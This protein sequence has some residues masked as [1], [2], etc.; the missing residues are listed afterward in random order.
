MSTCGCRLGYLADL[1]G[2]AAAGGREERR[3]VEAFRGELAADR[4]RDVRDH[5][6]VARAF[7]LGDLVA[8]IGAAR[9]GA[10]VGVEEVGAAMLQYSPW[11][12][13]LVLLRRCNGLSLQGAA[14]PE[15]WREARGT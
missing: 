13:K 8:A 1:L 14:W 2:A 5:G 7:G 9:S 12:S 4:D 10:A 3:R 15:Q 6:R 11:A